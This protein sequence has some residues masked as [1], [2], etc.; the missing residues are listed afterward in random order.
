MYLE[1]CGYENIGNCF[2]KFFTK[3]SQ[4]K[5][6]LDAFLFPVAVDNLDAVVGLGIVVIIAL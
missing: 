3:K 1:V 5:L 4:P 6:D 2:P